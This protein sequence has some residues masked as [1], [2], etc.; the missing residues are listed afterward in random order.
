[1][2]NLNRDGKPPLYFFGTSNA[3]NASDPSSLRDMGAVRNCQY[4]F[5]D[6]TDELARNVTWKELNDGDVQ[7]DKMI[8]HYSQQMSQQ[9]RSS[10]RRASNDSRFRS[11]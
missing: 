10:K 9:T 6:M 2:T 3:T 11:A 8:E 7:L 5:D 4:Q 1:M